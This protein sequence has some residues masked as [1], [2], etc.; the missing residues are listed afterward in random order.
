MSKK[1][2]KNSDTSDQS[3]IQF[4]YFILEA[5]VSEVMVPLNHHPFID[6]F[7]PETLEPPQP[8]N[9]PRPGRG[10]PV[11]PNRRAL[12][13]QGRRFPKQRNLRAPVTAVKIDGFCV[14]NGG[15]TNHDFFSDV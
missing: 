6:G 8:G 11:H 13:D 2:T 3:K 12:G 7:S 14:V 15:L 9:T 10:Q 5:E 4:C 1:G